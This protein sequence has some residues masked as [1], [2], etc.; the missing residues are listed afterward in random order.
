MVASPI[1]A[2]QKPVGETRYLAF[3][4]FTGSINAPPPPENAN[5]RPLS[6]IPPMGEMEPVVHDIVRRIGTVGKGRARLAVV[7]GP[8]AFDHADAEVR[9]HIAAAFALALREGVAV[10][11]HLDDSMFWLG[12]PDL[13]R[14]PAN[15]EWSDWEGTRTTGRRIDWGPQPQELGPQMCLNSRAIRAEVLRRSSKVIG[16]AIRDG[17]ARLRRVGKE[18]LFAGVIAGWETQIGRDFKTGLPLGFHALANRGFSRSHPPKD[19]DAERERVVQEWIALWG[20][21]LVAGGVPERKVYSHTAFVAR[22]S[23]S[24][25]GAS[26]SQLNNFAPPAVAFGAG[27]RPGFST[28]PQPG[29]IEQVY[30]E[31]ARHKSVGWASS[32]GTNL[33]LGSGESGLTMETYLARMFN[34]GARLVNVFSWGIGGEANRAMPFRL[35]TEGDDALRAYRKFLGG[36]P[37]VEAAAAPTF[38]ERLQ[39]KIHRIQR[40]LPEWVRKTGNQAQAEGLM[41]RLDAALKA[42]DLK[43][44]E[45]VAD[46]ALSL[47]ASG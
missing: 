23:F 14:D 22:A 2:F 40:E 17:L 15:L 38:A 10:G 18:A 34:H 35:A 1:A 19:P 26:Y 42:N 21:G 32:E 33:D 25:G 29:H 3:Q 31:I 44:A 45:R 39:G 5:S 24:G 27:H 30:G 13:V 6:P 28:Y 37:L 4:V 12:R 11:F 9:R 43:A 20:K 41:R 47:L 8:L 16:P 36:K 7:F 46:E